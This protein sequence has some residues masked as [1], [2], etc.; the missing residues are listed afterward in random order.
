MP[1]RR[2]ARLLPL[3]LLLTGWLTPVSAQS[4]L[5]LP[6]ISRQGHP[7]VAILWVRVTS[8]YDG[9]TVWIDHDLDS[10]PDV[11]V[12]LLSVSTPELRP[13]ECY[14]LPATYRIRELIDG[15]MVG[16]EKDV[17]ELDSYGRWLRYVHLQDG[18]FLNGL[19]VREGFARVTIYE[20]DHKYRDLLLQLQ[21]QAQAE[22]V[23]GWLECDW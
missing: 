17:S 6:L 21:Q 4:R 18:R 20:P 22:Q 8:V 5:C 14:G 7:E 3:Y 13:A 15:Q 12:R 11:K 1:A 16:L 10:Q 2:L 9:D 19:L 23:G